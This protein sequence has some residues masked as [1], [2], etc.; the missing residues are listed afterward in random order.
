MVTVRDFTR[1]FDA[2]AKFEEELLTARV[3]M[4]EEGEDEEEDE[5]GE[6]LE[7]DLDV[8]GDDTEVP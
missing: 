2:Y 6:K 7:D 4:L 3:T 5:D 1:I 8:D